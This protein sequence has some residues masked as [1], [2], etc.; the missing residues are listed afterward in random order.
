[1]DVPRILRLSHL[2]GSSNRGAVIPAPERHVA[3]KSP[4]RNAVGGGVA[5][6]GSNCVGTAVRTHIH[7][8]ERGYFS[9]RFDRHNVL[10]VLG[11][12]FQL[13][14]VA[15]VGTTTY[16][17]VTVFILAAAFVHLRA[18]AVPGFFALKHAAVSF[19]LVFVKRDQLFG[20]IVRLVFLGDDSHAESG[21]GDV[22]VRPLLVAID[23]ALFLARARIHLQA[24]VA[25]VGVFANVDAADRRININAL[26]VGAVLLHVDTAS[27]Q[28]RQQCE[29][30]PG[31]RPISAP[32]S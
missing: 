21:A 6:N 10:V 12:D 30:N 7:Q 19:E 4:R 26:V 8:R 20:R 27:G 22:H 16:R 23:V 3:A 2:Q 14:A 32:R 25:R 28:H 11:A 9:F 31:G 18:A 1:M 15:L 5:D 13:Y 29:R 17:L 24:D